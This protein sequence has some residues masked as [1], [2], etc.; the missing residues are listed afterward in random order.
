MTYSIL[1]QVYIPS[2]LIVILSFVSFWIDHKSVKKHDR[3]ILSLSLPVY[4]Q[5]PA[6]ISVG[7]LTVL[8]V[9]TQ[10]SG[11]KTKPKHHHN[12]YS[13]MFFFSSNHANTLLELSSFATMLLIEKKKVII[14]KS[15]L[16]WLC[17]ELTAFEQK[18][19]NPMYTCECDCF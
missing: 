8:T 12:Y 11:I 9:T 4:I 7:L 1:V 13:L 15:V 3:Y 17:T 10:S 18:R 5:V 16:F 14:R 19:P 6:R 2:M